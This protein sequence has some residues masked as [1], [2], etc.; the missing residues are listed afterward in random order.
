VLRSHIISASAFGFLDVART[1]PSSI[2]HGLSLFFMVLPGIVPGSCASEKSS[3]NLTSWCSDLQE[4]NLLSVGW[5]LWL[6]SNKWPII[7]LIGYHF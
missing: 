2:S 7:T 3:V 6:E 5:G 4:F 1:H